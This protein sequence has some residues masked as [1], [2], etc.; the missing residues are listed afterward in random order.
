[1]KNKDISTLYL[2]LALASGFLS[3]VGSRLN[4]W[5]KKSSG[6]AN[7][8]EYTAQVNSF[9]PKKFIPFLAVTSTM[10]ETSLGILLLIGLKTRWAASGAAFLTILFAL[11]MAI[12]YGIK[13]P[14][15]YSVFGFSAGAWALAIMSDYKWSVDQLLKH[16]I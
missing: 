10:L 2:R 7:Y 4:L 16:K 5:G 13:E 6:W 15:D 3:A 11:A 9:L 8:L 14:L 1:M 12:S